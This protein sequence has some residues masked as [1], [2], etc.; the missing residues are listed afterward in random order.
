M[1]LFT[2]AETQVERLYF[3]GIGG[4]AMGSVAIACQTMGYCVSGSDSG[5][6][7]PMSEMLASAGIDYANSYST[8]HILSFSPNVV[9]VGNAISRGNPA[10]EAALENNIPLISMPELLRW[11]F[12]FQA[13][14]L[15]ITG[16]HGKTTTTSLLAWILHRCGLPLGYL[17]G[18]SVPQLGVSCKPAPTGGYFVLEGDEYDTAFFDKRS[19]FLHSMPHL[20]IITSI[21]YDHAD[22]F[23]TIES[24]LDAFAKLT[25][26]V[27]RNGLVLA[28]GDDSRASTVA[29]RSFA[30]VEHYGFSEQ[31]QWRSTIIER[32]ADGTRFSVSKHGVPYGEFTMQL[33]GDHNVRNATAAIAA[34]SSLGLDAQSI[35]GALMEYVPPKRRFEIICTWR[36]AT[37]VDDF[38]H[39][40][41]AISATLNAARSRFPGRRIVACV[42]PRSNTSVRSIFQQEITDALALADVVVLCPIYRVERFAPSERLDRDRIQHQLQHHGVPC[43]CIADQPDWGTTAFELLA[44]IVKPDDV[45]LLLSNG[46]IGGLRQRILNAATNEIQ[47]QQHQA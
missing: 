46:N 38:A 20:L 28:C 16:T 27:P 45:L 10:L 30:A 23:P 47:K 4:I 34:A 17:I 18:G 40:P 24:V 41:T 44:S 19:K 35:A 25:L 14:R 12:M 33:H 21:E 2:P 37:V 6:Y 39:H 15:V 22:I 36:G 32:R 11:R 7:P 31:C 9:V 42:E 5:V 8:Q 43:H 29:A 1:A 3:L 13:R 26:Q